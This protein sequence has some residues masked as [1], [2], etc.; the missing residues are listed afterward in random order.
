MKRIVIASI[1]V[2]F[3]LVACDRQ[4][5]YEDGFR[6]PETGWKQ[7]EM[8]IFEVNVTDT[9]SLCNVYINVRNTNRY[10]WMELWLFVNVHTPSGVLQ[11]DTVKIGIADER[12]KWLGN[13]LGSK[14]DNSLLWQR[15]VR[16]PETGVY[17]FEY[18]QGMRDEPLLGVD[19]IGLRIEKSLK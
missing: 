9:A 11:R 5:I 15:N 17:T 10:K 12:G 2:V 18:E 14:F 7:S 4:K 19:D 3:V 1:A 13:G 16:F 8:A 6:V